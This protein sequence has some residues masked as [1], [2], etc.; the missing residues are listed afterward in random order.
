MRPGWS[1]R[2]DLDFAGLAQSER[3]RQ[4]HLDLAD[5]EGRVEPHHL[6]L[7]V[8]HPREETM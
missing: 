5:V 8:I 6:Q 1:S 2:A 4:V 7:L 3:L